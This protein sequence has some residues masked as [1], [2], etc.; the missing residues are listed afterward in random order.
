MTLIHEAVITELTELVKSEGVVVWTPDQLVEEDEFEKLF[1]ELR[2]VFADKGFLNLNVA[3]AKRGEKPSL[4]IVKSVAG[5]ES[6]LQTSL[7]ARFVTFTTSLE[8]QLRKRLGWPPSFESWLAEHG[9]ILDEPFAAKQIAG[10]KVSDLGVSSLSEKVVYSA[11]G[12]DSRINFAV[13]MRL[14]S[15]GEKQVEDILASLSTAKLEEELWQV[16]ARELGYTAQNPSF[17]DFRYWLVKSLSV[18]VASHPEQMGTTSSA[19]ANLAFFFDDFRVRHE[20]AYVQFCEEHSDL[21]AAQHEF[22]KLSLEHLSAIQ[23]LPQV[24]R[25]ILDSLL[26]EVAAD[27]HSIRSK[28]VSQVIQQRSKSP[29]SRPLRPLFESL[30]HGLEVLEQVEKLDLFALDV[31][32]GFERYTSSWFKVDLSYRKHVFAGKKRQDVSSDFASFS[33]L[34]EQTYVNGFQNKLG[35]HW[36]SLVGKLESWPSSD[37]SLSL[38]SFYKSKVLLPMSN[39]KNRV[40]VVI[41]DALRYEIGAELNELLVSEGYSSDLGYLIAPL[42]SYTQLGM[43]SLLPNDS[44]A[45]KPEDKTVTVDDRPSAGL[46]NRRKILETVGGS[47]ID[48]ESLVTESKLREHLSSSRLWYI[49]HNKIDKVGDNAASEGGVFEAVEETL[50]ELR[51]VI[52]R[53]SSAGFKKIFVTADHGFL[54]QESDIP[55]HGFLST[56]PEGEVTEF[57]NRRF[58]IGRGLQ[59]MLGLKTFTSSQLG[60]ECDYEIQIPTSTLRLRRQGSG[61]RFVHG[62]AT[63]QEVVVPVL[64]V[65]KRSSELSQVEI[66]L[67]SGS[68]RKITTGVL[69]LRLAQDAAVSNDLL[70][71]RL[72]AFVAQG[73]DILSSTEEQVFDSPDPESRNRIFTVNLVLANRAN[74]LESRLVQVKLESNIP[75]TEQW[76]TYAQFDFEIVNLA[77]RDF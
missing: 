1:P 18:L 30:K 36:S 42:P 58:I 63:L 55:A 69:S 66:S 33:D 38:R 25:Q 52:R 27:W 6:I 67:A 7:R 51:D 54:Y 19:Q 60:Y 32:S 53:L 31:E 23:N 9:A 39:E 65:G 20:N 70:P 74:T 76:T 37:Q 2:V 50:D 15:A 16:V 41:S 10:L 71:R 61:L 77:E 72:R 29:W 48:Y 62:G 64:S 44:I 3:L 43:A 17:L 26:S 22:S 34:V 40:A 8:S 24:D 13:S 56:V 28:Y 4:V 59:E 47:A 14:V 5:D 49:Y 75:N 57:M 68:P 73:D 11:M 46:A 12:A 35:E 45:L 21:I